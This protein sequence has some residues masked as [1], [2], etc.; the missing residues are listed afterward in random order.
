MCRVN[1]VLKEVQYLLEIA[2]RS[3]L[4]LSLFPSLESGVI[5]HRQGK[6]DSNL[7]CLYVA[8]EE[9]KIGKSMPAVRTQDQNGYVRD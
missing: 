4:K 9:E 1:G 3:C 7:L 6:L 2:W 8:V 5:N